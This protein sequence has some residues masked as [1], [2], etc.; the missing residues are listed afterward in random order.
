[1]LYFDKCLFWIGISR[2]KIRADRDILNGKNLFSEKKYLKNEKK[3][4][5]MR[6]N[7]ILYQIYYFKRKFDLFWE[8]LL[9]ILENVLI[10]WTFIN[11]KKNFFI[12]A[13][14]NRIWDALN[15]GI[16]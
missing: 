2:R 10:M 5:L 15:S 13:A 3:Y 14:R 11:T 12:S 4:L 9:I 16:K 7:I 1:M 8:Y 6:K